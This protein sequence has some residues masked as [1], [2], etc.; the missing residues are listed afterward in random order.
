[1]PT[2]HTSPIMRDPSMTTAHSTVCVCVCFARY[3]VK[4]AKPRIMQIMP[5]FTM[6]KIFAEFEWD[7]DH[8]LWG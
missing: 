2:G 5:G 1:M 4:M 8:Q 6:P 7:N 3:C